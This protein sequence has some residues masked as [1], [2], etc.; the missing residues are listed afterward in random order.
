MEI[1]DPNKAFFI[2]IEG[3]DGVGKTEI[4]RVLSN[5]LGEYHKKRIYLTHEPYG[6]FGYTSDGS[7]NLIQL[8]REGR[9][10]LPKRTQ[11]MI[12]AVNR[13]VHCEEMIKPSLEDYAKNDQE[14]IVI[15]DRYIM[16]SLAYQ[17]DENLSME[18][19]Y[20]MNN[21]AIRPNMTFVLCRT[22]EQINDAMDKRKKHMLAFG[23]KLEDR[24]ESSFYYDDMVERYFAVIAFMLD[25]GEDIFILDP[26]SNATVDGAVEHILWYLHKYGPAWLLPKETK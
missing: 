14:P 13:L 3:M 12:F 25:K 4:A 11:A 24:F 26:E 8:I 1:V 17:S 19:I 22:R 23:V 7:Y 15:C 2:V 20:E 21:Q 9:L 5:R 18:E 6:D 10:T 16:S